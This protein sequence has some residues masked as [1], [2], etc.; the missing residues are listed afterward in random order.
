MISIK[1]IFVL[2]TKSLKQIGFDCN[3]ETIKLK[4]IDKQSKLTNADHLLDGQS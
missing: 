3:H 4:R 2:T 1:R